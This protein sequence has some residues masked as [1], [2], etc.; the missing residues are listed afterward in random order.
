MEIIKLI[1]MQK[2]RILTVQNS[3]VFINMSDENFSNNESRKRSFVKVM[4]QILKNRY[5]NKQT[6]LKYWITVSRFLLK[7]GY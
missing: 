3:T 6:I 2:N 5:F 1:F 4:I 7:A